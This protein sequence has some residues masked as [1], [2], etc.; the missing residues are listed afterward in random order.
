[1]TSHNN[2]QSVF[3]AIANTS[4]IECHSSLRRQLLQTSASCG[5]CSEL[6]AQAIW[7]FGIDPGTVERIHNLLK[8]NRSKSVP[9]F[10]ELWF[11]LHLIAHL[12]I[13][14]AA[15]CQT[16]WI[17]SS[18]MLSV[19]SSKKRSV[20]VFIWKPGADTWAHYL[21]KAAVNTELLFAAAVHFHSTIQ[22]I[23]LC[24]DNTSCSNN[25]V[26]NGIRRPHITSIIY[27]EVKWLFSSLQ[28]QF[29]ICQLVLLLVSCPHAAWLSMCSPPFIYKHEVWRTILKS[30]EWQVHLIK[31]DPPSPNTHTAQ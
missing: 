19:I 18:R 29:S 27:H 20:S 2:C 15:G 11:Y 25:K 7:T 26:A 23:A 16:A 21:R 10:T 3:K 22:A 17:H 4:C 13:R 24:M 1:M 30:I 8:W 31:A 5:H 9:V 14:C 12:S 6:Y 28:I